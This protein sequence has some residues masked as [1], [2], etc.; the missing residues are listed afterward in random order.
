MKLSEIENINLIIK[1][2]KKQIN[3]NFL[4]NSPYF[5]NL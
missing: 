3:K 5:K 2:Q 4:A 1:N